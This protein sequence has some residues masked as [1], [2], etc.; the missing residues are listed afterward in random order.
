MPN[1][2][3]ILL[4]VFLLLTGCVEREVIDDVRLIT[5]MGYDT[6]EGEKIEGTALIPFHLPDQKVENTTLS[7]ASSPSRNI[8]RT[9]QKKSP[10]PIV[11]GA[12]EVALF[13]KDIAEKGISS[14]LDS[15][16]RDPSIGTNTYFAVVDGTA[17]D[18]LK[19]DYGKKGNSS[20]IADL[21]EQNT[22]HLDL[23]QTNMHTF[24]ADFYKVGKSPFLPL[25]KKHGDKGVELVGLALF[26][27]D[28]VIDTLPA[29]K[30]FYFKL[31]VERY[32]QG[33]VKVSMGKQ[34]AV[35]RSL[36]SKLKPKLTGQNPY[37]LTVNIEIEGLLEQ[38]T[39]GPLN[40]KARKEIDAALKKQIETNCMELVKR[41]QE[42]DI[43]PLGLGS[44][45]RSRT[46]NF[47]QKK[48]RKTD[49]PKMKIHV[50]A[51]VKLLESG[52]VE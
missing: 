43:D 46:R 14:L 51:K 9:L 11:S 42:K 16:Q 10:D 17:K 37:E 35:V 47:D 52:V 40:P 2:R 19:G 27:D 24:L 39:G 50:N 28:K 12:M 45:V 5:G 41:Y 18:V 22:E 29:N 15:L 7:A 31:M 26:K 21:I 30:L 3:W 20:Y 23:P 8:F 38:Y 48:W 33:G 36:R 49:Y 32:T 6:S 1:N 4:S 25:I 13:G 44:F 34:E